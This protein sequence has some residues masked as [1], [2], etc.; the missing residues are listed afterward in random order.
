VSVDPQTGHV[1]ELRLY[2]PK[3]DDS[4]I[5]RTSALTRLEHL[6]LQGTMVTASGLKHVSKLSSL[7]SLTVIGTPRFDVDDLSGALA[8]AASLRYVQITNW[9]SAK[10]VA[11]RLTGAVPNVT[12]MF[13]PLP[14]PLGR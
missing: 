9:K 11:E 8:A 13:D 3:Y 5:E 1:R 2:G 6:T 12:W 7:K 14:D 4:F 10:Q